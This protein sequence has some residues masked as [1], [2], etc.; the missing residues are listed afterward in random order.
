[1][2]IKIS[3]I[4]NH[5]QNLFYFIIGKLI[6]SMSPTFRRVVRVQK[7]LFVL[8]RGALTELLK[9]RIIVYSK[10]R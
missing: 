3:D 8:E 6:F 5:A 4:V 10:L 1:M 9:L 7:H 2:A